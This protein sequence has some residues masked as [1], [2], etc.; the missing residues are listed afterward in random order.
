[1]GFLLE[2]AALMKIDTCPMEGFDP[3]AYDKIL[4]LENTEWK[5][6]AVV[7]CGYRSPEDLYAQAKKVRFDKKEVIQVV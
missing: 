6:V 5:S 1:M 2:T 3:L 7:T 4:G